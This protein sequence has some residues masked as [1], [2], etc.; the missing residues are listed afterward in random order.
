MSVTTTTDTPTID[1]A[2]RMPTFWRVA[3]VNRPDYRC[4]ECREHGR[5][6]WVDGSACDLHT[7]EEVMPAIQ[8]RRGRYAAHVPHEDCRIALEVLRAGG[9][10]EPR[11]SPG[12]LAHAQWT[13]KPRGKKADRLETIMMLTGGSV[14]ITTAAVAA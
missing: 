3:R 8:V 6:A 2:R 7:T 1:E 13:Y 5:E 12:T 10:P 11:F 9:N 14:S 4:E